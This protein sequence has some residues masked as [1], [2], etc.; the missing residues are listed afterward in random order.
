MECAACEIVGTAGPSL[1]PT[2]VMVHMVSQ[3]AEYKLA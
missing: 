2:Y 3:D 1:A